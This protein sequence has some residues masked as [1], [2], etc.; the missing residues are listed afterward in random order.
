[1]MQ[2]IP[3]ICKGQDHVGR[4]FLIAE[5]AR[6]RSRIVKPY[7]VDQQK[8]ILHR[9]QLEKCCANEQLESFLKVDVAKGAKECGVD[10][11]GV[12]EL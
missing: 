6:N 4:M 3:S 7:V 9:F 8:N 2:K 11:R 10:E 1:M 5:L 12:G